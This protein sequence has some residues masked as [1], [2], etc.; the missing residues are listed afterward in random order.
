M[1]ER[2]YDADEVREIFGLATTGQAVDRPRV[3]DRAGLTLTDLRE[4]GREVGLDTDRVADA[5]AI[6]HARQATTPRRPALGMPTRV[7]RIVDLPRAPTD[8]E[9]ELLVAELR[10]TFE[11]RGRVTSQGGLREWVNGN[12]HAYIE[13]AAVGYRLRLTTS[14][15]NAVSTRIAGGAFLMFAAISAVAGTAAGAIPAAILFAAVGLG[16][17]AADLVR[18]PRWARKREGQMAYLADWT[19]ALLESPPD[20]HTA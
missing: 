6:L 5:V 9:W 8:H 2:R 13:P 14:K 18:L 3:S 4:I 7:G 20:S 15:G 16:V 10:T 1:T 12:L 11:A 17:F 19:Q